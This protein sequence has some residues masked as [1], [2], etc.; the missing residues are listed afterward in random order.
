MSDTL[1]RFAPAPRTSPLTFLILGSGGREHA[2][3]KKLSE[4]PRVTKI[5]AA[6]GNPGTR[7]MAEN[8][9][10]D[11]LDFRSV[12]DFVKEKKIDVTV[13][14]PEEPLVKGIV[15]E[16]ERENLLIVGPNKAAAE[17]EGSKKFAKEFMLEHNIPTAKARFFDSYSKAQ[18]FIED[19]DMF[20]IVIKADGLAA[21]KGVVVAQSLAEA[22]AALQD[23]LLD[24]RFGDAG[25]TVVVE[26]FMEG[27]EASMMA[28]VD[29]TAI[30]PLPAAQDHKPVFDNDE[31]PNTGGMGCFCPPPIVNAKVENQVYKEVFERTVEAL[32]AQGITYKG[33]LY[34]G[35]MIHENYAK[36]VEF[37]VR[38]GDP[39]AQAVL[40]RLETDLASIFE[41]IAMNRLGAL[42]PEWTRDFSMCLVLTSGGYPGK[43]EVGF[44]ITGLR[45]FQRIGSQ[46][47]GIHSG[48]ALDRD[49]NLITNGGRVFTIACRGATVE[50]LRAKVY[51]L[52]EFVKFEGMHY[53]TDIGAKCEGVR[54][55]T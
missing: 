6:P 48:T 21:G 22:E 52:A 1:D 24:K 33:I 23:C 18:A 7:K 43:Y 12:V 55:D 2:I 14:G 25:S 19:L 9:T 32:K 17:L 37:N 10:L 26:E 34:A 36:V 15:D 5:Y 35:L 49:E 13:V 8:V 38:F 50:G 16:F 42:S 31:G 45:L 4:S 53:R 47:W 11:I 40:I 39:E 28:F 41:A 54:Y 51:E 3:V 30:Y 20:P 44:P 27:Q 46:Y 29:G